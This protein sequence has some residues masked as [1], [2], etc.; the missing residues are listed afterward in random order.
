MADAELLRSDLS[1]FA[2]AIGRPMEGWQA[3][4]LALKAR[5]TAILAPRQAGKS[6]SLAIL[7]LW[8]AFRREGQLIL[9]ISASDDAAKRLLRDI[10]MLAAESEILGGSILIEQAGLLRLSNGSEIRS[11]PASE[12]QIRGWSVDLLLVDEAALVDDDLLLGAA[13]PTVIARPDAKIVLAS[14]ANVASGVFYDQCKLG[15]AGSEHVQTFRW[16]LGDCAWITP[17]MVAVMRGSMSEVRFNAEMLGLWADGAYSLFA[18]EVLARATADYAVSTL[19]TLHGP[20][21]LLGGQDWGAHHDRS[22]LVAVGRMAVPG[23][24][25]VFGVVCAHRWPSGHPLTSVIEDIASSPAHW[26]CYT[27]ERNGLG[28]ACVQVLG[29]RLRERRPEAG[30]APARNWTIIDDRPGTKAR[31][32]ASPWQKANPSWRSVLNPIHVSSTSKAAT[33]SALRLLIDGGQLLLPASASE[34]LRELQLLSVDLSPSGDEHIEASTGHDDLADALSLAMGPYRDAAGRWRTVL[35]DIADPRRDPA[36]SFPAAHLPHVTTGSGLRVPA[37]G[38]Y[39][40]VSGTGVT[41]PDGLLGNEREP[42]RIG[43]FIL[44]THPQPKEMV[45]S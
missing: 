23:P 24:R 7:A 27:G 22:A 38:I 21:R 33:Y 19:A 39:Q 16:A 32:K 4:A 8:V 35:G 34:L 42:V 43:P 45:S 1:A 36:P 28:E 31:Q 20:A 14:S 3:R 9:I 5:I 37:A 6:R 2:R 13:W 15:E 40:S 12:R 44:R 30:G 17:S 11:V 29:R 10:R 18:K 26:A 41:A 25:P